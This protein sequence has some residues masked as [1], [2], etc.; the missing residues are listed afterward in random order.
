MPL[1]PPQQLP[2][3]GIEQ[4]QGAALPGGG[5]EL[6]VRAHR[7]APDEC[8]TGADVHLLG[9]S[10]H[11]LDIARQQVAGVAAHLGDVRVQPPAFGQ[12]LARLGIILYSRQQAAVGELGIE[13]AGGS[14]LLGRLGLLLGVL[15]NSGLFI[16]PVLE[17]ESCDRQTDGEQRYH[18]DDHG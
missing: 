11:Q 1:Q 4:H 14:L 17:P 18:A 10:A 5:E 2:A 8:R 7:H 12:H 15:G 3:R 6:A 13:Q 9:A 16:S